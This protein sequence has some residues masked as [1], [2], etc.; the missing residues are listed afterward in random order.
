MRGGIA[1]S[2]IV[3][4]LSHPLSR[5]LGSLEPSCNASQLAGSLPPSSG[6]V[7]V[8]EQS[9]SHRSSQ[10]RTRAS[11]A[12][13]TW[14]ASSSEQAS[15]LETAQCQMRVRNESGV[16]CLRSLGVV[17]VEGGSR[18]LLDDFLPLTSTTFDW[19]KLRKPRRDPMSQPEAERHATSILHQ[20]FFYHLLAI[21]EA[22]M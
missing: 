12:G 6:G 16:G 7:S 8:P 22:Y 14:P 10:R 1:L 21:D 11:P 13:S 9:S 18:L 15:A 3:R 17:V 5:N 19:P 2:N 4:Q 20:S